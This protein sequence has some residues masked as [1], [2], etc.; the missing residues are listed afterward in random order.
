MGGADEKPP[1]LQC[2]GWRATAGVGT[3]CLFPGEGTAGWGAGGE[4]R[5]AL[6]PDASPLHALLGF[7]FWGGMFNIL[8]G[9]WGGA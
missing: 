6:G 7:L 3:S 2:P 1:P 8:V 5:G 4:E 9:G